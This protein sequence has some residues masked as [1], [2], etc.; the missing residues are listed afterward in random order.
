MKL[1][2]TGCN[3]FVGKQVARSG[4]V[5][6]VA[7][8]GLGRDEAAS[9]GW[10]GQYIRIPSSDT[11]FAAIV[12]RF[13]P[14]AIF[15]AA[16]SA[17]VQ[18]SFARPLEDFAASAG[19]WMRLL[20]AVRRS[21]ASPLIAFPSSAAVYGDPSALPVSEVAPVQPVSPYGFHK[22]ICELLAREYSECFASRIIV[23]RIFSLYGPDQRRLLP[24]EIYRQC[25]SDDNSVWLAGTGEESRDYLDVGDFA[26]AV[27]GLFDALA[28]VR[29]GWF[30]PVNVASGEEVRVTA[31]ARIIQERL[32]VSKIIRCGGVARR[33]D[34]R[35]W[36]ADISLLQS[37]I[38]A[39]QPAP[40]TESLGRCVDAWQA[41]DIADIGMSPIGT[42]FP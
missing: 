2:I 7:L 3:G 32:A 24:W 38:P 28:D 18:D 27:F 33:G 37:L 26:A 4:A 14:D 39:W 10:P 1:L 9:P 30:L 15:H 6:G 19:I 36:R 40:F 22:A 34:P 42:G 35:R 11:E 31:V 21:G 23:L 16:G 41:A 12:E 8:L 17:S 25:L 13:G 20:D 29:D 5:R